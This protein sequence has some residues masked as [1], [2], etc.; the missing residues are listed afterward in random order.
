VVD[1]TSKHLNQPSVVD[2]T[3]KHL[4][5]PSVVDE[6]APSSDL[7]SSGPC[8]D[9]CGGQSMEGVHAIFEELP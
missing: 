7:S 9:R 5:Q 3:S 1:E 6:T 8:Y 2:E 4:D